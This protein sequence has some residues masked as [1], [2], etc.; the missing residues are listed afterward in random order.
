MTLIYIFLGIVLFLCLCLL[1]Y[2]I[3]YPKV[4]QKYHFQSNRNPFS[5]DYAEFEVVEIKQGFAKM[6]NCKTGNIK[7]YEI[8]SEKEWRYFE[9]S[10]E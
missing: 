4:G 10:S 5:E 6:K 8:D 3:N 7:T 1:V 9:R 2:S